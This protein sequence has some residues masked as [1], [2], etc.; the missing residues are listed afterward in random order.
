VT[1][2]ATA[3]R[4]LVAPALPRLAASAPDVVVTLDERDPVDA[5]AAVASGQADVGVVHNW[6]GVPLHLPPGLDALELGSDTADLLVP[7]GHRLARRR[8]VRPADLLDEPWVSTGPGSI[9]HAWFLHMYAGFVRP[10]RVVCWAG[11]FASHIRLVQQGVAVALVPRLGRGALP[12]DV[13][14]VAVVD[15]VPER[16]VQAVWRRTQG[17][18]PALRHV[19]D[20]F[21]AELAG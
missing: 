7:A 19:V 5:A 8:R 3:V 1:A 10:P 17:A 15:P 12:D 9:C 18:S 2:F 20:T 11:E 21:A 16:S 14:A 4:G 13:V 6:A